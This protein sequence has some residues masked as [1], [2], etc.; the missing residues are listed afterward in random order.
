MLNGPEGPRV[1]EPGNMEAGDK[2]FRGTLDHT[3]FCNSTCSRY[4]L[5]CVPFSQDSCCVV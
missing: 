4:K 2:T 5:L 3:E 1:L